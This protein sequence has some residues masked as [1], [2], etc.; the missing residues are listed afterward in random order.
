[1][2]VHVAAAQTIVEQKIH[3][4]D[5]QPGEWFGSAVALE[6]S[7]AVVG[8]RQDD[9]NGPGSGSAYVFI[10][11]ASGWVEQQKLIASDGS[12][13]ERFGRSV[14]LSGD[15]ALIGAYRDNLDAGSAYVFMR[16]GV[17]W[18]QQAKLVASD[19]ASGDYF[20]LAVG[21]SGDYAVVGAWGDNVAGDSSGSAY[22][23]VR[24]GTVWIQQAKLE[25]SDGFADDRFGR[26]VAISGD[27]AVVGA[28]GDDDGGGAAGSVYV[29]ER[30]GP[31][32]NETAKLTA[33][34]GMGGAH[35][36]LAVAISGDYILVGAHTAGTDSSGAAYVFK[37]DTTGWSETAKLTAS[38]AGTGT[39]FGISVGIT[40][41]FAMIGSWLDTVNGDSSGSAYIFAETGT[42]WSEYV[43]IV[44]SDGRSRDQF[45][46]DVAISTTDAIAGALLADGA[47]SNAG[48]AY[49]YKD[50]LLDVEPTARPAI[51]EAFDLSQNYPNPFN[52]ATIIRF[53]L[54]KTAEVEL[55]VH[56]ILG[57]KVR[58]LL[59]RDQS[60]GEHAV[61]WDG[62]NDKGESVAG[63]MYVYR[64]RTG[65]S[66]QTRKMMLLK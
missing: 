27:Y 59:H 26:S 58:T 53:V 12:D 4:A 16:S 38:D 9:A 11:D 57:K 50:V 37:R 43:K 34:D 23:F 31:F 64:L 5:G 18:A 30:T 41:G 44:P 60:A 40:P 45:G 42:T 17:T 49:V 47:T 39:E 25:A 32:W 55:T 22:I 28:Y 48:A 1:M 21:L 29:F 61:T 2:V 36:G 46:R 54:H 15:Y 51:P 6:E 19:G 3:A 13:D 7:T 8:A 10:K 52:P 20:G 63:A 33:S 56:D 24:T 14:S 66:I 65:S 62:T 35:F